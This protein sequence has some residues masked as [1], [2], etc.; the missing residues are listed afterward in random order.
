VKVAYRSEVNRPTTNEGRQRCF[1]LA[2]VDERNPLTW[3]KTNKDVDIALWTEIGTQHRAEQR[4][5]AHVVLG[6]ELAD[7]LLINLN[8]QGSPAR[9][10]QPLLS[11][12]L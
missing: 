9:H 8:R 4:K 7:G 6:A 12:S 5:F 2:Q 11:W 10:R 3:T 1:H